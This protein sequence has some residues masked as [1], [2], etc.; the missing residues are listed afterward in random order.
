MPAPADRCG[1]ALTIWPVRQAFA[2]ATHH[3]MAGA[4]VLPPGAG[5]GARGAVGRVFVPVAA[6]GRAPRA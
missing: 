6:A 5:A 1:A 4:G 3:W 2:V